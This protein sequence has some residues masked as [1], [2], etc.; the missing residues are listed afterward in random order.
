MS[1]THRPAR[2]IRALHTEQTVT[3]YQ[4]YHPRIGVPAAREGRFPSAWKRERMTWITP[5]S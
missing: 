3:V 5:R 4:A 1:A 2:E